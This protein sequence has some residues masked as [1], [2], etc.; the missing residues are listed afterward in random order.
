MIT[1]EEFMDI[2]SLRKDGWS[3]RAIAKKL[4]IHRD[5]VKKHLESDTLPRYRK[6]KRKA[7]LLDPFKQIR[8]KTN[9]NKQQKQTVK[10]NRGRWY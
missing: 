5:T 10:T 2:H 3:M 6:H 7:S 8:V 4:G 1:K 9:K